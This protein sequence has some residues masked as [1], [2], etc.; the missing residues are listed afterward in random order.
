MNKYSEIQLYNANLL[1]IVKLYEG[2]DPGSV[3]PISKAP[4]LN[5]NLLEMLRS[6]LL[7]AI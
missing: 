3:L 2:F 5:L 6:K 4:K 1:P 7:P